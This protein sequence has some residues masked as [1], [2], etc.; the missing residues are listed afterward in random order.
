MFAKNGVDKHLQS[1]PSGYV[2]RRFDKKSGTRAKKNALQ[3]SKRAEFPEFIRDL[4]ET[5]KENFTT[6]SE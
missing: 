4:L 3:N 2:A 6:I 1:S 5:E